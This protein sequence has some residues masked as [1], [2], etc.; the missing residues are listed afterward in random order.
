MSC[1]DVLSYQLLI[2][3]LTTADI[4]EVGFIGNRLI[5]FNRSND[6]VDRAPLGATSQ[7]CDV[8]A[9]GVDVQQLWIHVG[10]QELHDVKR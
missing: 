9:V 7:Y 10:D 5:A 4:H 6:E 1:R 3:I 2:T 8:P